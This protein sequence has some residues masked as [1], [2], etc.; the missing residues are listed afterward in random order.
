VE[1]NARWLAAVLAVLYVALTLAFVFVV[2]VGE[3][4]DEPAHIEYVKALAGGRL[5]KAPERYDAV[6]YQAHQPPLAYLYYAGV[7]RV[8]ALNLTPQPFVQDPSFRFDKPGSRAFLPV[9]GAAADAIRKL[10]IAGIVWGLCLIAALLYVARGDARVIAVAAPFVLSPQFLFVTSTINNDGALAAASAW[11]VA[12]MIRLAG[13][14]RS[15][16]AIAIVGLGFALALFAKGSALFLLA[17]VGVIVLVL[18]TRKARKASA[19]LA[20]CIILSL[21]L[22]F[23]LN[24]IRFESWMPPVPIAAAGGVGRLVSDPGWIASLGVSYWGKFGWLN[25][26]LPA[27]TYLWFVLP[28]AAVVVGFCR[29]GRWLATMLCF[30][31]GSANVALV[32]AYLV[33]IDWQPQGRYLFPSTV[34]FVFAASRINRLPAGIRVAVVTGSTIIAVYSLIYVKSLYFLE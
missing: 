13:D 17:P 34:A 9:A 26:P 30:L 10:R 22:W 27:W 14:L 4:P 12:A 2:P 6:N 29:S 15:R 21:G 8:A 1:R 23:T 25:T 31:V 11:A 33:R 24:Q 3:A 5:P 32:A 16:S 20:V 19:T 18:W 7:S 28:S